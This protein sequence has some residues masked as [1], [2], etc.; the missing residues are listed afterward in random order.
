[1]T[2]I[3]VDTQV[4]GHVNNTEELLTYILH[5]FRT[6]EGD[7]EEINELI[8]TDFSSNLV[9]TQTSKN[10]Y[11]LTIQNNENFLRS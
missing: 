1:M 2:S 6:R 11:E 4:D 7:I 5:Y 8:R 9:L 10:K 3:Y